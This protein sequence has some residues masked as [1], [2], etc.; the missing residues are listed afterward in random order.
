MNVPY[1]IR[2]IMHRLRGRVVHL[3]PIG[4]SRGNVLISYTT[5]PYLDRRSIVLAAHT[6]RWECM[7]MARTFLERGYAVDVIDTTDR[8]FVPSKE[9]TY[10]IDAD[11]NMDRLAPLLNKDCVKI[12]YITHAHWKYQ[13]EAEQKRVRAI[14]EKR[15]VDV[16]GVRTLS[17]S[18]TIELCDIAVTFAGDFCVSTYEYAGKKIVRIPCSTTHEFPPPEKKDFEKFRRNFIWVGGAGPALKRLDVILEAFAAMPEYRLAVCGK[19]KPSDPFAKA[20][21]KE[22]YGTENIKTYGWVDHAGKLF[23]KLYSESLG[24]IFVSAS[25][26]CAGSVVVSMHAGLIPIV[27][28]ETGVVTHDFGITLH[29]VSVDTIKSAV[30]SL[31]QEPAEFLRTR[32]MNTWRYAREH[33]MREKF[34]EGFRAF[35]E[36]LERKKL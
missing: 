9:Y 12:F 28:R 31:S 1:L 14:Q 2:R 26:G 7:Q 11:A 21:A 34:A 16:E 24:I 20:Y 27:S 17:A 36:K 32:S 8:A 18:H 25:E 10:F 23:K 19:V 5:L 6:N 13:N 29:E 33:Y 4:A 35:V 15:G 3:K 22:L 30:R